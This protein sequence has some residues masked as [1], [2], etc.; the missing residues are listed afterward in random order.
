MV[1]LD[2]GRI[3]IEGA[4]AHVLTERAIA[5][6]YGAAIDVVPVGGQIAVVPR[7]VRTSDT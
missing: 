6:H 4:P 7:R 2:E 1:L 5:R 3:A